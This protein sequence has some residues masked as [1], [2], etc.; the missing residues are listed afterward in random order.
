MLSC[1]G[2]V[3]FHVAGSHLA[4]SCLPCGSTEICVAAALYAGRALPQQ[5]LWLCA[6]SCAGSLPAV[7]VRG[8]ACSAVCIAQVNNAL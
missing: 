8:G 3:L 2:R 6:R 4:A 5:S 7:A 1:G